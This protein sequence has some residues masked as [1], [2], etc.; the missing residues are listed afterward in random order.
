M[1]A[2][3]RDNEWF[4]RIMSLA[5]NGLSYYDNSGHLPG[6]RMDISE[7]LVCAFKVSVNRTDFFGKPGGVVRWGLEGCQM[8][9]QWEDLLVD[10]GGDEKI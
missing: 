3:D 5:I 8:V 6:I 4:S 2:G 10:G 9:R 7:M 1:K